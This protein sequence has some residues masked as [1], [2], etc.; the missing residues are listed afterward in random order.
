MEVNCEIVKQ[1]PTF[2]I[3]MIALYIAYQQ[4]K[5]NKNRELRESRKAKL[6]VYKKITR[7]LRDVDHTRVVTHIVEDCCEIVM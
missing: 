6:D 7:F 3:G 4:H 2:V 1:L 5:T